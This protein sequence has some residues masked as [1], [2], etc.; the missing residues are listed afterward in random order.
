MAEKLIPSE[1]CALLKRIGQDWAPLRAP[2]GLLGVLA[3]LLSQA[4]TKFPACTAQA[5]AAGLRCSAPVLRGDGG[6]PRSAAE[7]AAG[8]ALLPR[9]PR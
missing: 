4:R 5:G 9:L 3:L 6:P 2:S 1:V 8:A 7:A